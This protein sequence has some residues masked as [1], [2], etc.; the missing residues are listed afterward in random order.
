M[1]SAGRKKMRGGVRR[2]TVPVASMIILASP[3]LA[4]DYPTRPI[5]MVVP[6]AAGGGLDQLARLMQDPLAKRLGKPII[7]DNRAGG[8]T[9]IGSASVAKAA[10]DGYTL[11][12]ATST[13]YAINVT[14]HKSL[15]YDPLRDLAPVSMISKAPFV[16]VV[17]PSL[18]VKTL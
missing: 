1:D 15:P 6:Y 7:V 5:T 17:T 16:F 4:Q 10:P 11:L 13:A 2:I 3:A 18:P 9:V 12:F 8:G 14:I